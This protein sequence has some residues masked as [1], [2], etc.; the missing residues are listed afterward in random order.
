MHVLAMQVVVYLKENK[1]INRRKRKSIQTITKKQYDSQT[2]CHRLQSRLNENTERKRKGLATSCRQR[3]Q[4]ERSNQCLYSNPPCPVLDTSAGDKPTHY[5]TYLL[6]AGQWCRWSLKHII[7]QF[8]LHCRQ[9]KS[10]KHL[11]FS[12]VYILC[13]ILNFL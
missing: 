12:F 5:P 4:T 3:H 9:R 8:I 7:I 11:D 13:L 6:H 2:S 1:R 10:H